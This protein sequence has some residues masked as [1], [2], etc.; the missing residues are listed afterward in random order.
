VSKIELPYVQAYRD[1][2][3]K[4]RHYLR[5]PGKPRVPLPGIPGSAQF[6]AAYES[7]IAANAPLPVVKRQHKEGT[8]GHL[9][10]RFYRSGAFSKLAPSS[11]RTY[12]LVLDKFA[13]EDG[14]RLVRDMPRAVA[15]GI[16]EQIGA[17]RPGMANLTAATLKRLFSYAVKLGMRPDNPFVGVDTYQGGEHRAWTDQEIASYESRWP[18]GTRH[19]LAFDLLLYTGQRVGDVAAMRRADILAG[20]IPV[21]Q[22]KTGAVLSLPVHPH[23]LRSVKAGPEDGPAPL[24]TD[25]Q[26]MT[27]RS[28]SAL[29]ARAAR[30]AGLPRDC[31]THGLRKAVLTRLADRNAS[32][33]E[34]AAVSGHKSLREVQHYTATANQSLLARSA[35]ARLPS[36]Q[37]AMARLP[38][39]QSDDGSV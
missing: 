8:I 18:I 2:R 13:I 10:D 28:I 21:K 29:V 38:T 20:T 36:D 7:A 17:T 31:K 34:I 12:R 14:H 19:R 32:V 11:Q 25:G 9:V 35:M 5:R 4:M 37:S 24:N 1:C 27:K 15:A 23:L 30:A 39:E 16:V 6:M 3:G 33:H 26:P 22:E